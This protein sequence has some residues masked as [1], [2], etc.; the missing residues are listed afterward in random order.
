VGKIRRRKR[1]DALRILIAGGALNAATLN[2][3]A[4]LSAKLLH[5]VR[6]IFSRSVQQFACL[7]LHFMLYTVCPLR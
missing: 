6:K 1:F 7:G 3:Q 5:K 4:G 2:T